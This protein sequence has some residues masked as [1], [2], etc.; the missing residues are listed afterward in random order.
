[1][2]GI[3]VTSFVAELGSHSLYT[4]VELEEFP[5]L[6]GKADL[7]IFSDTVLSFFWIKRLLQ[8]K[9]KKR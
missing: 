6:R 2:D 5:L 7:G 1:M 8:L 4:F 9:S 3:M